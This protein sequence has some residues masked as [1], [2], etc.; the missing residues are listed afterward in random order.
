ME[1]DPAVQVIK[2]STSHY[3]MLTAVDETVGIL[4][5]G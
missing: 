4:V 1:A 5:N 2:I 3:C